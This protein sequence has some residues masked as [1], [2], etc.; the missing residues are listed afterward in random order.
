MNENVIR[1][2]K[3]VICIT[4]SKN[5]LRKF[6]KKRGAISRSAYI[7]NLIRKDLGML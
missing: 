7:E 4:I 2:N 3:P 1:R 5:V 6:D